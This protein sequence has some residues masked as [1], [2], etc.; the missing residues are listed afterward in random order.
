M[1]TIFFLV[2]ML[3]KF[4]VC[5]FI[6]FYYS[7]KLSIKKKVVDIVIWKIIFFKKLLKMREKRDNKFD[8]LV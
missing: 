3:I 4:V 2:N 6:R 7:E 5:F 1:W 8:F